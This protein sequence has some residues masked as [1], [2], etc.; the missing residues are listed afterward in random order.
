[1]PQDYFDLNLASPFLALPHIRHFCGPS[2]VAVDYP[3]HIPPK[4]PGYRFGETLESVSLTSSCVDGASFTRFFANAKRLKS[5]RYEHSAKSVAPQ[6]WDLCR[7][8]AAIERQVGSHLTELSI[9]L[10]ESSE[11]TPLGKISFRG[12]SCLRQLEFPLEIV[13]CNLKTIA[14]QG[15]TNDQLQADSDALFLGDLIPASVFILSLLSH[16]ADNHKKTLDVIFKDF[17]AKKEITLPNLKEIYLMCPY[18]AGIAY[19]DRCNILLAEIP[20]TGVTFQLSSTRPLS[21][22]TWIGGP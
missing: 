15:L 4:V 3:D 22:M 12:F 9:S 2:C 14:D 11:C 21:D 1:M 5:F 17:A 16:D 10:R 7:F 8:I 18:D 13:T 19:K 6:D 20:K